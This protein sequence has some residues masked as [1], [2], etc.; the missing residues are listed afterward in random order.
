MQLD[1]VCVALPVFERHAGSV[2]ALMRS[3]HVDPA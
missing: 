1:D 2:K 3:G